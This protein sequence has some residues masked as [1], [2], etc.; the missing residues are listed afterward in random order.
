MGSKP[1]VVVFGAT[2]KQGEAVAKALLK[3]KSKYEVF[4]ATRNPESHESKQMQALGAKLIKADLNDKDSI[5]AAVKGAH[6]VFLVTKT[7]YSVKDVYGTELAQIKNLADACLEARVE[8]VV[9]STMPKDIK[10]PGL[11]VEQLESKA[12]GF[13]YMKAISLPIVGVMLTYYFENVLEGY[14]RVKKEDGVY[15]LGKQK[16]MI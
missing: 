2:G 4:G 12:D 1:I 7:S 9:F 3:D 16:F 14:F 13:E 6:A 11:P 8:K 10:V 5:R 15:G